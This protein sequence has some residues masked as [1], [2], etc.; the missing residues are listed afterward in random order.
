[1]HTAESP[2]IASASSSTR[3]R[4]AGRSSYRRPF[5]ASDVAHAS[6]PAVCILQT[7]M[8]RLLAGLGRLEGL[9]HR[10]LHGLQV[11]ILQRIPLMVHSPDLQV[12]FGRHLIKPP[13]LEA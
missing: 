6:R 2:E 13:D 11:N 8:R 3:P 9:S 12:L 10:R 4:T 5:G 7:A 1:M